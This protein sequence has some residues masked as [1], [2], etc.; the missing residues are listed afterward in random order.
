MDVG[1]HPNIKLLTCSRVVGF[2]PKNG[3]FEARIRKETRYIDEE[4]CTGCGD[5]MQKCPVRVSSDFEMALG[6][7]PAAYKPYLQGFPNVYLIDKRKDGS[8]PC[9]V[10]C[11]ANVNAHAYV[12]L[13]RQKRYKEALAIV[14][15]KTPLAG[16]VGRV[17]PHP[18]EYECLRGQVD[19]PI[20]ICFIKRFL[21]DWE[22]NSGE[23]P[24]L[25]EKQ[26]AK[27]EKVA[28]VGSGPAGLTCGFDLA[29]KGYGVTIFEALPVAGG[30]LAVGIPEHR[31]PKKILNHEID[32]IKSTG[33]E[34]RTN[35]LI[36]EDITFDDLRKQGY[37]A[38][39]LGV[40]AHT[41][42]TLRIDGEDSEGV[43]PGVTF[44]RNAALGEDTGIGKKAVVI[45]G[46]NV[47]IDAARTAIRLGAETT[48]LYR[49]T[50]AEMPAYEDEIEDALEENV[51]FEYLVAPKRVVTGDNGRVKGIE[52]YRME[53]GEPDESGRRRPVK[54]EG[55][56]F[57][58]DCD[59]I[60]P[61]IGQAPSTKIFKKMGLNVTEL[62]TF[63]A[64]PETLQTQIEDIFAA[65]DA[66]SGPASVIEACQ[67][68]HVASE[69]IDR[70]LR[71]TDMKAD[72]EY[73]MKATEFVPIGIKK[74]KRAKMPKLPVEKRENNF[75]EVN[76]GFS[77][78]Q[79]VKEADRCLNCGICCE[80]MIC[81]KACQ[82]DAI[83]HSLTDE[84]IDLNADAVIVATGFEQFDAAKLP[85]YGYGKIK[86]VITGLEME[87]LLSAGG[88]TGGHLVRLDN[89]EEV[90]KVA[91]LQCVGSRDVRNS[92]FCSSVCC[93]HSTKQAII[94]NEHDKGLE[95][96]IFYT[97]FRAVGK[98][99][100]KYQ[101]RAI[102]DSNTTYI[103]TR[104]AEISEDSDGSP[105]V[106]YEDTA[107]RSVTS[108]KVDLVVLAMSLVPSPGSFDL[109]KTLGIDIDDCGFFETD[110][111][112]Q[113]KTTRPGVFACGYCQGPLDV[114]ESVMQAS[115]ASAAAAEYLSEKVT[116]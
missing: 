28:I 79:A 116:A 32:I 55:S 11:P 8:S 21:A 19:E 109:A 110:K 113:V 29:L 95:S 111:M 31:L 61:A 18:C 84:I 14:R 59:T 102:N 94:A 22:I 68:G 17:C 9:K 27:S 15:E 43:L 60:I 10:T 20:S 3:G 96:F 7:R 46:G 77:E 44:L 85:Q 114:P 82:A 107:S 74:A 30:M 52:C 37:S 66:V 42:L 41:N 47:A 83:N 25:P 26:E 71:G 34:I 63:K 5:C 50:R 33:V 58:I 73:D 16:S 23:K 39:F 13:T 53:L 64:D 105:V 99:F 88:P 6:E 70:F 98:G 49:R 93:M 90:H 35:A 40:G 57:V 12:A 2:D 51:G 76:L 24:E 81:E 67:G 86:N 92:R 36:G 38:I 112:V 97:D 4:K 100:Q 1:R 75:D 72:R 48:I 89:H 101:Q 78:E 104:V 65:G 103:R 54:L 108:M 91:F 62:S 80:C 69:S 56:E 106:W 45:G 87:R 115:A